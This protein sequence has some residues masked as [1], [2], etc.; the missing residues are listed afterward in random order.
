MRTACGG[1]R[2]QRQLT[3]ALLVGEVTRRLTHHK[4]IEES[5]V[6]PM[7]RELVNSGDEEE[8]DVEHELIREGL[9]KRITSNRRIMRSSLS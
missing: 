5:I 8:S 3:R 7:I 1:Y 4:E 6:Y 9:D 2:T